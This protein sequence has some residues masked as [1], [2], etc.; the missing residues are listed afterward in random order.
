[1][2]T[3]YLDHAATT[4]PDPQICEQ[5]GAL[6]GSL[7]ANPSSLHG[8]GRAAKKTLEESR[9]T[10]AKLLGGKSEDLIFTGGGTES[11]NMA[12][13][14]SIGQKPGRIAISAVEHSAIF[15]AA[16][17]LKE[18]LGW[19]VD[20][21]P[22]DGQGRVTPENLE[23]AIYDDTRIAAVMM[24]NNE[25][26]TINDIAALS[27][28]LKAKAPRSRFIVDAV[29]A[30]TKVPFSVADLGADYVAITAHKLHGLKGVGALW[31]GQTLHPTF[32]GG[33]QEGGVRG[34]TMCAALAWAFAEA[35]VKQVEGMH[36]IRDLRDYA[37]AG[38]TQHLPDLKLVGAHFEEGRL[39]NNLNFLIPGLPSEPVMNGLA[40]KGVC[41][42]AG[43]ACSK[44]KFSKVLGAMGYQK[45]EGA[46]IRLSP[47]RFNTKEEIDGAIA[48]F[49]SV[50][51]DLKDMYDA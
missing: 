22:V 11:L 42:S 13:W 41:V 3:I 7:Y 20:V 36:H 44:N 25:V 5:M 31:C 28:I 18:R 33:A 1:M 45:S 49:V 4:P 17:F 48:A 27:R 47:G 24:A 37:W 12:I 46:F 34:G 9:A 6:L 51:T 43:S 30:F 50:I 19:T 10:I 35:C 15:A 14:G 21:I 39:D 29:Q 26:G 40:A 16:R 8:P 38:L 32:E 2:K 23:K